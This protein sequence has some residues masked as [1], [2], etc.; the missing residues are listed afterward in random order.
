LL[1]IALSVTPDPISVFDK[2]SS[3]TIFSCLLCILIITVIKTIAVNTV[4][5]EDSD[6]IIF[7]FTCLDFIAE[8]FS[9]GVFK[10][11]FWQ[12][13]SADTLYPQN[14]QKVEL[15]SILLPHS[16]QIIVITS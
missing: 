11:A 8:L 3:V 10:Y 15:S 12:D 7:F 13:D 14:L 4:I 2:S 5:I 6:I 16:L 9:V 1:L